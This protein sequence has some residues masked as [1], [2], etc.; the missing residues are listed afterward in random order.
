MLWSIG[1][2]GGTV[3]YHIKYGGCGTTL[4]CFVISGV[5]G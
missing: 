2:K 4:D 3:L 5:I 1:T